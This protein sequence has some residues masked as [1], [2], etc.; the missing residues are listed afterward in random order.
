[1]VWSKGFAA[2][3]PQKPSTQFFLLTFTFRLIPAKFTLRA[4]STSYPIREF[5]SCIDCITAVR[6]DNTCLGHGRETGSP[7]SDVCPKVTP[8]SESF[9]VLYL[10]CIT[11]TCSSF[12]LAVLGPAV[13]W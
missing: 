10:Q 13:R 9:A 5:C 11:S 3:S 7:L 2:D 8:V 1:M 6:V 12:E 4:L